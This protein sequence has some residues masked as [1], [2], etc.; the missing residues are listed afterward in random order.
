VVERAQSEDL[1]RAVQYR[2]SFIRN[3]QGRIITDVRPPLLSLPAAVLACTSEH[4]WGQLWRDEAPA[5]E[6][7]CFIM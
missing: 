1:N 7:L 3:A 4:M 5:H 6:T 2:V